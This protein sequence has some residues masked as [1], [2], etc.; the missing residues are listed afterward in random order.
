MVITLTQLLADLEG[1]CEL[2]QATLFG[3]QVDRA[4]LHARGAALLDVTFEPIPE[5]AAQGYRAERCRITVL[6][7]G[8]IRSFPLGDSTRTWHHR[9]PS[10]FGSWYGNTAGDLCLWYPLD[11]R[12]LRWEWEDGLEEYLTRVHRHLFFEEY[13][14]RNGEWPV[15]DAPHG[16]PQ[17]GSHPILSPQMKSAV[18][19][20]APG[21]KYRTASKEGTR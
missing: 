19:Q 15:E 6:A 18:K 11:P 7:D 9:N 10:P 16:V 5:F 21:G 17:S 14:R 13:H 12:G 2:L 8:H 20:W 3:V 4:R 1:T